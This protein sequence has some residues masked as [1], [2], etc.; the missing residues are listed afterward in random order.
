[1]RKGLLISTMLVSVA[2]LGMSA[3]AANQCLQTPS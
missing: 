1:M 3:E 2:G